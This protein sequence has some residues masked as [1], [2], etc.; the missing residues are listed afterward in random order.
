V[1]DRD[2][3]VQAA[4][5]LRRW[6]ELSGVFSQGRSASTTPQ[7]DL[8]GAGAMFS[9]AAVETFV[10]KP[11]T[12]IGYAA[13]DR[14]EPRVF[15][16]T[17]RK[18]TRAEE[19]KLSDNEVNAPV[20]F[21]VAQPFSVVTPST[22]ARFP[23]M[24]H[25]DRLTCGSSISIGNAREAG[26]L[27]ALLRDEKGKLYGL[28]CNHVT[29]GCSNARVDVPIV[30]PGILDVGAGAPNP[31]TIGLHR[32]TLQFIQGDPSSVPTYLDN[33][34]SAV[35]EILDADR[36]SSWQGL[37]YD[38][39]GLAAEPEEDAPVE[40]VGRTTRHTNG[41]I[42]SRLVGP[43]RIDYNLTIYHSAEENITFRGT[44]FFEPVYIVRGLGGTF[45]IEG[46][47]GAIVVHR[48]DGHAPAAVGMVIGGRGNEETYMVP[49]KPVL[50]KFH[51]D[52]VSG[53][54]PAP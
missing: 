53:H 8:L 1:A 25:G 35:F 17:R 6:A 24:F 19:K 42:E 2:Q 43:Q 15:I 38:T 10:S 41:V 9:A 39:P 11:I 34:D 33:E 32:R 50:E 44:V 31:R 14:K 45:A 27:G 21:R 40:K 37:E 3:I 36:V 47:S 48:E 49:L 46:D 4:V 13:S 22:A 18:L 54:G 29:G 26:T 28:S 20:E 30:A 16:Y 7:R 52:L 23:A 5:E 51:L 12:A